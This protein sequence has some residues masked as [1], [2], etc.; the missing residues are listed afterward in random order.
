MRT[1]REAH[2]LA[3]RHVGAGSAH[4]LRAAHNLAYTL[5]REQGSKR[6]EKERAEE[7]FKVIESALSAARIN[8]AIAEGNVDFL[9]AERQ[10][11]VLLCDFR[12]PDDGIRRFWDVAAIARKHH[13][14][15]S[16]TEELAFFNLARCLVDRGEPEGI[17]MMVR[18]YRMHASRDEHSP[19]TLAYLAQTVATW[20]CDAGRATECAE[21]TDKALA[22]AAAMPAGEVRSVRIARIRPTQV[23]ALVLQGKPEEAEALA[24]Q[25][26]IEPHWGEEFLNIFRSEALRL[27]GRFDDAVRAADKAISIARAKGRANG[28][29][30][31]MLAQRG[32]AELES[33]NPAQ[34]L[35]S[36]EEAMPLLSE[37]VPW[38]IDRGVVPLAY[39][40]ALLA[41]GRAAEALEALRQSYGFWLGHDPKSVWAAEAE[42]W[43][44]QAYIASG[45]VKRGRWMVAEAKRVL[46]KSPFKL[47]QRLVAGASQVAAAAAPSTR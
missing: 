26:L 23:R 46:A 19:W 29:L 31:W 13:G 30:G 37:T 27:S 18:T 5:T 4:Q 33:G 21:F 12:S 16:L 39:G 34:A 8:P 28:Q 47:H 24:A 15:D 41:N 3:V 11:G 36:V 35:V 44:G 45:D 38:K 14:D 20:Q 43:F 32:L 40:R 22:H 6:P 25:F 10:Y 1:S 2:D 42:Y 17:W 7:A 9:G